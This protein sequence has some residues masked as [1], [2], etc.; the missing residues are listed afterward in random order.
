MDGTAVVRSKMAWRD[1]SHYLHRQVSFKEEGLSVN[2]T[3]RALLHL[4]GPTFRQ[5]PIRPGTIGE[6]QLTLKSDGT[7]LEVINAV[8]VKG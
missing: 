3:P 4:V 2:A 5:R 1:C 6:A 8:A 7:L